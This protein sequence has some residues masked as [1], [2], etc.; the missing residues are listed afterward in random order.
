MLVSTS[1]GVITKIRDFEM[2]DFRRVLEIEKE[3]FLVGDSLLYMELYE[4]YPEGFLIAEKVGVVIGF[5]V[6][7]LTV[8]DGGR[9]FSIAVDPKYRE[10]GIGRVLLK[11]ALSNLRKRNIEYVKLEVRESN[12]IA[13][14]LYRSMGFVEIG[15]VP[16]YYRDGEGAILMQR[17]L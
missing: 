13:Q 15:F 9:I 6:V 16:A 5:V 14:N 10:R 3:S 8:E 17:A 12:Y 7:V 2:K 4:R 11:A 1:K